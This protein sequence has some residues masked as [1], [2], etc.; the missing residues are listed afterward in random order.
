MEQ[1]ADPWAELQAEDLARRRSSSTEARSMKRGGCMDDRTYTSPDLSSSSF[2][3]DGDDLKKTIMFPNVPDLMEG[4]EGLFVDT[5]SLEGRKKLR[6]LSNSD[7]SSH[8]AHS[9]QPNS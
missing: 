4:L 6:C 3:N 7:G 8:R 1:K 9:H 5:L 2:S